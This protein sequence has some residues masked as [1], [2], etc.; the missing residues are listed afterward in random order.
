M[1]MSSSGVLNLT[2]EPLNDEYDIFDTA[3]PAG[4]ADWPYDAAA[5]AAFTGGV[6]DSTE[7]TQVSRIS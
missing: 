1:T 5:V 6:L 2:P 4:T 3:L 7:H